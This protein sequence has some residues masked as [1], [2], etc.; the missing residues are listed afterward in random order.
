[1]AIGGTLLGGAARFF[2]GDQIFDGK[3]WF[4]TGSKKK[5]QKR[6]VHHE[7]FILGILN[8]IDEA[9]LEIDFDITACAQRSICWHVKNSLLNVQENKA[10]KIDKFIAGM[11]K[12]V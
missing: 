11:T 9:L 1:M 10:R 5:K 4:R 6:D 2:R 8:N 3:P 12:Y 7:D